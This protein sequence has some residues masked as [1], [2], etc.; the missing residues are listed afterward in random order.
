MGLLW[1]RE[2]SN[3]FLVSG[4][5]VAAAFLAVPQ[6]RLLPC[7]NKAGVKEGRQTS[8]GSPTSTRDSD[9][10]RGTLV[11]ARQLCAIKD[12]CSAR[13]RGAGWGAGNKVPSTYGGNV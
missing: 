2:D 4:K 10:E 3:G 6:P 1:A 9:K 8:T 12:R 5:A 7:H 11:L 13:C